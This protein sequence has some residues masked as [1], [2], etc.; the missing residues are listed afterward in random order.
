VLEDLFFS[1]LLLAVRRLAHQSVISTGSI[2]RATISGG[3]ILEPECEEMNTELVSRHHD[4]SVGDLTDELGHETAVDAF[5]ALVAIDGEEAR[6]ETAV[7]RTLFA[8]ASACDLCKMKEKLK[9]IVYETDGNRCP[10]T[11]LTPTNRK[12]SRF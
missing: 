9:V 3:R 6:P 11:V 7:T 1:L 4:G 8:K 10:R 5:A 2:G 12:F